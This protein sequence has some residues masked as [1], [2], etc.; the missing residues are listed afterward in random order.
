LIPVIPVRGIILNGYGGIKM[1]K[2]GLF[3]IFAAAVVLAGCAGAP[4][5][6]GGLSLDE[7]LVQIAR[8]LEAGLPSASR[9]AVVNLDS[10]SARFSNYVLDELQGILTNNRKL[11]VVDRSQLDLLKNEQDFQ[12]SGYV[13][14]ETIVS[15]GKWLGV[16]TI[17]SGSL[18]DMGGRNYR[19]RFNAIDVESA[20]HKAS[21][22]VIVRQDSTANA[23]ARNILEILRGSPAEKGALR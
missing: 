20:V 15:L 14:D 16:Q 6:A 17:V 3:A 2:Q 23:D 22:A 13:S 11:I 5:V 8:E 1:K 19:L 4:D 9:I 18:S 7:G 21:P 12:V 10:P